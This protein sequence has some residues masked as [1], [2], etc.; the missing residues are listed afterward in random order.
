M[1]L[2]SAMSRDDF[3]NSLSAY[4]VLLSSQTDDNAVTTIVGPCHVLYRRPDPHDRIPPSL[5]W[6]IPSNHRT[7]LFFTCRYSLVWE[8]GEQYPP[9]KVI[10]YQG[11]NDDWNDVLL[12][13]R[14]DSDNSHV[15]DEENDDDDDDDNDDHHQ[16]EPPSKRRIKRRRAAHS[17]DDDSKSHQATNNKNNNINNHG[18]SLS[19]GDSHSNHVRDDGNENDNDDDDDDDDN[20]DDDDNDGDGDNDDDNH[21]AL[22]KEA[23]NRNYRQGPPETEGSTEKRDIRIGLEHQVV[24][25]DYAPHEAIRSRNPTL[26]WQPGKISQQELDDYFHGVAEILTPF[27]REHGLTM[28][29]P[30]SPLPSNQMESFVREM[31]ADTLPTLSSICT[32]S[33]LSTKANTLLRECDA[34]SLMGVL[35]QK[36]YK[37]DDALEVIRANPRDYLTVWSP[38]EKE[39]FNSGFRRYSG[40]LRMISKGLVPSKDFKDVIDYHYRFKIPDQFRR[41]QDK[42]R[43]Q[44]IRMMECIETRR[45]LHGA[46][47]MPS[48]SANSETT[49]DVKRRAIDW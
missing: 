29:D 14:H 25:P 33:S 12:L 44:A 43:E 22:P 17:H 16:N 6:R 8:Q 34:D 26:V 39:L 1:G 15:D 28:D 9:V 31:G 7:T 30:Y 23:Y 21:S 48:S 2:P 47:H 40:S 49:N 41:F 36:E 10:P 45:Y 24:I 46:I 13:H 11:E 20:E 38:E 27:V 5:S 35:H 3:T 32:A 37:A 19:S 4:D 42:K 18:D